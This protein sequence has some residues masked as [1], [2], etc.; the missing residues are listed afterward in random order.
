MLRIMSHY[1]FAA[2]VKTPTVDEY[3]HRALT[4][5]FIAATE[6]V[7]GPRALAKGDLEC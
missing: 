3:S 5:V 6:P 4:G 2:I 1:L 7:F